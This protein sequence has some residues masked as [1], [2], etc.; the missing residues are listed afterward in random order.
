ML[1][2]ALKWVVFNN[3]LYFFAMAQV[4]ITTDNLLQVAAQ[5]NNWSNTMK[6]IVSDMKTRVNNMKDWNDARAEQFRQQAV[7]TA[8]QLSLHIDNF[9]KMSK[10]LQKY[11][12]L[13]VEAERAQ[14]ARMSNLS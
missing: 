2:S 7:M 1:S 9:T 8:Q 3:I 5:M 13:Q 14:N 10:F 4:R 12:H 6:S 11:A